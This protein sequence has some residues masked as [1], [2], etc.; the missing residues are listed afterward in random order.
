LA[1]DD[2]DYPYVFRRYVEEFPLVRVAVGNLDQQATARPEF[3]RTFTR[4]AVGH[5]SPVFVPVP[6]MLYDRLS[7]LRHSGGLSNREGRA[8]Q[9]EEHGKEVLLHREPP[10]KLTSAEVSS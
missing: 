10:L 3:K 6:M 7:Q 9:D 5:H 4:I 1:L 8:P 2:W